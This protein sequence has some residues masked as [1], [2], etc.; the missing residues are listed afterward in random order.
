LRFAALA[1]GL[2]TASICNAA[3]AASPAPPEAPAWIEPVPLTHKIKVEARACGDHESHAGDSAPG[4]RTTWTGTDSLRLQGVLVHGGDESL[5]AADVSAWQ[6]HDRILVAYQL[7]SAPFPE[8]PILLCE[9]FTHIDI[10][11]P[12]LQPRPREVT[13]YA[14]RLNYADADKIA[15]PPGK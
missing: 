14:G 15:V 3:P 6:V 10:R 5:A 1:I 13:V 4:L 9:G 7:K 11:F 2:C 12:A 8:A